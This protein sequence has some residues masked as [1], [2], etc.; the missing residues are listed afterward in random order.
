MHRLKLSVV[1]AVLL[2]LLVSAQ[3]V[4]R[5]VAM[6]CDQPASS[7]P[8]L[9]PCHRHPTPAQKPCTPALFAL[10]ARSHSASPIGAFALV[11]HVETAAPTVWQPASQPHLPSPPLDRGGPSITILRL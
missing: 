3:C 6:P 1:A 4:A 5:C 8:D 2:S 11:A 10:A 7:S 9:P